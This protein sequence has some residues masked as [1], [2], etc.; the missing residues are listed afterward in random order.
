MFTAKWLACSKMAQLG[1]PLKLLHRIRGGSIDSE[2]K[3]LAVTPTAVPSGARAVMIVTPVA[4]LP[5]ARRKALESIARPWVVASI[6]DLLL[7]C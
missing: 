1:L 3:L 6:W 7:S 4:K 2:L 5:S